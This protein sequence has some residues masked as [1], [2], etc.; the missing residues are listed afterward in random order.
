[1]RGTTSGRSRAALTP[2]QRE[3]FLSKLR[4]RGIAA[5]GLSSIELVSRQQSIPLSSAQQ[6]LW[7]FDQLHPGDQAYND[8][9]A[10]RFTG[11]LNESLLQRSMNTLVERHEA[12]RTTFDVIDGYPVQKP[13]ETLSLPMPQVVLAD[14]SDAPTRE[15]LRSVALEL[16]RKPFDLSNGPLIRTLLTRT[17]VNEHVLLIVAHHIISDGHSFSILFRELAA[18]YEALSQGE[19]SPLPELSIRYADYAAWEQER[20]NS[21]GVDVELAFWQHQLRSPPQSSLPLDHRRTDKRTHHG[22]GFEWVVP[23]RLCVALS[24][25][26][27]EHE[28]TRFMVL[29]AAFQLL[30]HHWSGETDIVTGFPISNRQISQTQNVF[31]MFVNTLPFRTDLSGDPDLVTILNRVR[32]TCLD[33][34][35]RPNVP[36]EKI[37]QATGLQRTL[38]GNPLFQAFVLQH[39]QPRPVDVAG[40]TMSPVLLDNGSAKLDLELWIVDEEK[41]LRAEDLTAGDSDKLLVRFQFNTALFEAATIGRLFRN[42]QLIVRNLVDHPQQSLSR[43]TE[44]L[45]SHDHKEDAPSD[46]VERTDRHR[47]SLDRARRVGIAQAER[48]RA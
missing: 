16:V 3:L 43:L 20:L 14:E 8:L 25:F 22:A 2:E 45:T 26:G 28:A 15:R 12:L 17:A 31:G 40:V 46:G 37:I 33:A 34:Y 30:L 10:V 36:L 44:T 23:Q 35:A 27:R 4:D 47:A 6:R 24:A 42:Y 48:P 21:A 38:E 18:L 7:F 41:P 39:S 32:Q 29:C 13:T 9:Y 1:M 5:A 11:R 19:P